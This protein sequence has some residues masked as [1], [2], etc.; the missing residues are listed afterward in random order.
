M[1]YSNVVIGAGVAAQVAGGA[2]SSQPSCEGGT[3]QRA[4]V[5]IN[6]TRFIHNFSSM[7]NTCLPRGTLFQNQ[8]VAE[9]LTRRFLRQLCY[10]RNSSAGCSFFY[11][12]VSSF[13]VCCRTAGLQLTWVCYTH[14][15][16]DMH[17]L[18]HRHGMFTWM[19]FFI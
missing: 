2:I 5:T 15:G 9:S 14:G 11:H 8:L 1:F 3:C 4:V 10:A 18:I 17:A 12:V 19:G 7:V 13:N 6:G 16:I